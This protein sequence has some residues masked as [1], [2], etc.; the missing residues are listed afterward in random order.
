MVEPPERP[1]GSCSTQSGR[2]RI[3][4]RLAA[5]PD[6]VLDYVLIPELAHLKVAGHPD[7]H[8]IVDRYQLAERGRGYLMAIM[9]LRWMS[10]SGCPCPFPR[11][12]CTGPGS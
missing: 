8:E 2:I 4:D 10:F 3:S 7:F 1:L 9:R 12:G 11:I 5:V 6:F